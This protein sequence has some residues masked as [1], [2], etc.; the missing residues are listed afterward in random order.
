M[1]AEYRRVHVSLSPG[2]YAAVSE[3]SE[4]SGVNRGTLCRSVL[5]DFAPVFLRLAEMLKSGSDEGAYG[6]L[7]AWIRGVKR[8]AALLTEVATTIAGECG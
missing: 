6:E 4:L 7:N 3:L 1:S 8:D 2:T 5:E